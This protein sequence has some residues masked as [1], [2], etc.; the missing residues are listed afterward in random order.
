MKKLAFI[1]LSIVL[2]GNFALGQTTTAQLGYGISP[3]GHPND[4]SQF[5]VFLQEVAATCN[6]GVVLPMQHGG[7]LSVAVE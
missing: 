1:L 6:G 7:T 4:F 2:S 3:L 5:A